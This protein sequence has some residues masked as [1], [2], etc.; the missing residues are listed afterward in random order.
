[1]H[2]FVNRGEYRVQPDVEFLLGRCAAGDAQAWGSLLADV[3][4]LAL[5][6]GRW[7]YRLGA[8]DA[9]DV[10]QAVQIR[11]SERLGQLRDTAAFPHWVRRLVH[12]AVVDLIRQRRPAVRL[13]DLPRAVTEAIPEPRAGAAFDQIALRE[14]LRRALSRLPEHYRAP[15][16]LHVLEGIPQDEVGRLLGRPRSTVA[17]QI[18]R[19]LKRLERSLSGIYTAN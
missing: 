10:A 18:E 14:D 19:G 1:M 9:E 15:I 4:A 11:I 16:Q 13:D 17:S 5:R 12:H 8:E 2:R 7:K 3:R 6:L